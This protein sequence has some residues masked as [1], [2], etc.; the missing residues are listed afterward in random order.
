MVQRKVLVSSFHS[1][2]VHAMEDND[3]ET[4]LSFDTHIDTNLGGMWQ[5]LQK[6]AGSNWALKYTLHRAAA[7]W[8]MTRLFPLADIKIVVPQVGLE[9]HAAVIENM[10]EERIK[11][12]HISDEFQNGQ[13]PISAVLKVLN[14]QGLDV[15]ISP[16]R[17]PVDLADLVT[18]TTVMDID[19]DY[20]GALQ[21]ECYTPLKGA[22][23]ASLGHLERVLRLIRSTK[24][25]MIT[26]SECKTSCINDA[27]S[28]T[29]Y[30]LWKLQNMGYT[31][32]KFF[33]FN[34][35]EEAFRILSVTEEFFKEV[36]PKIADRYWE[37]GGL[38]A[39]ADNFTEKDR[40]V[41][42]AAGAFFKQRLS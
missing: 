34:T 42:E 3:P 29:S 28:R 4:I 24:P 10:I 5:G 23:P 21:A 8:I 18:D 13:G 19:V 40:E 30:I 12:G 36:L 38:D 26:L 17:D 11:K 15:V 31:I 9:T 39:L 37:R 32:E 7:H 6:V 35:D 41:A 14:L 2:S 27:N 22:S 20:F 1:C 33:V 25:T 16:P